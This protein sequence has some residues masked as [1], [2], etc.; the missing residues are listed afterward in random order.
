MYIACQAARIQRQTLRAWWQQSTS[1]YSLLPQT[2]LLEEICSSWEGLMQ[3]RPQSVWVKLCQLR[4]HSN[5]KMPTSQDRCLACPRVDIWYWIVFWWWV[6]CRDWHRPL[7][8]WSGLHI[9]GAPVFLWPRTLSNGQRMSLTCPWIYNFKL[10][11][12]IQS[13]ILN[14]LCTVGNSTQRPSIP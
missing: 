11:T 8:I 4:N 5:V 10:V 9:P 13:I 7:C 12:Q 1:I 14:R 2:I 3:L 6:W